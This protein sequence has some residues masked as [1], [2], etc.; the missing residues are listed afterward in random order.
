MGSSSIKNKKIEPVQTLNIHIN[1]QGCKELANS[2]NSDSTGPEAP[3]VLNVGAPPMAISRVQ[4]SNNN[5]IYN[6]NVQQNNGNIS[7][8]IHKLINNNSIQSSPEPNKDN[9][10][11]DAYLNKKNENNTNYGKDKNIN[12]NVKIDENLFQ[13]KETSKDSKTKKEINPNMG[14][15][16]GEK[17][18]EEVF[19]KPSNKDNNE[20]NDYIPDNYKFFTKTGDND[21]NNTKKEKEIYNSPDGNKD[22]NKIHDSLSYP[23]DNENYN[24][25]ENK[26]KNDN[27]A[28]SVL[29]A[30]L[31]D[32]NIAEPKDMLIIKKSAIEKYNEGY[33]PLFVKMNHSVSFYYLKQYSNLYSLLLAH[34]NFGKIPFNGE[35]YEFYNKGNKLN[36]N[37][38]V[39]EIEN[40]PI[41]SIIE[42]KK[43]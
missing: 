6:I 7:I 20:K 1:L 31:L 27:L 34:L 36:P 24:I 22:N 8:P 40:L 10:I 18:K 19:K 21:D 29:V 30:S 3:G 17:E 35:N 23:L 5:I 26:T 9:N 41:L 32:L 42:I 38:P 39:V 25:K 13:K 37:I 33:F 43:I 12:P 2:Q 14:I 28:Q 16:D 4:N 11:K 15:F